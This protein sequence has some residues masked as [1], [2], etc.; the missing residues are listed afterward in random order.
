MI[1]EVLDQ[2][3]FTV[4][5]AVSADAAMPLLGS[6][7]VRLILRAANAPHDGHGMVE[8]ADITALCRTARET[9]RRAFTRS[10]QR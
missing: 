7:S 4:I 2:A 6:E 1:S 5:E 8:A 10:K 3:G 9:Q